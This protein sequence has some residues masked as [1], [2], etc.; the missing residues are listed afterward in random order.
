M[1]ILSTCLSLSSSESK[2]ILS[3]F[4][5]LLTVVELKLPLDGFQRLPEQLGA[6]CPGRRD[7]SLQL[8]LTAGLQAFA[9]ADGR[10]QGRRQKMH[11]AADAQ[12]CHT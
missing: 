1:A 5:S 3:T 4:L 7:A 2:G 9:A 6:A 8:N 10:W 12:L 11:H